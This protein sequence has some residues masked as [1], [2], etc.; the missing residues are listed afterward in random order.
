MAGYHV[1]KGRLFVF[2]FAYVDLRP[3]DV[4]FVIFSFADDFLRAGQVLLSNQHL[5]F[6]R[7]THAEIGRRGTRHR[8][9]NTRL[10]ERGND[11]A[12]FHLI[13]GG[14]GDHDVFRMFRM[15]GHRLTLWGKRTANFPSGDDLVALNYS[16]RE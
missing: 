1:E 13:L 5:N 7:Y 6:A 15:I 11:H 14:S 10:L 8:R 4:F 3:V 12:R 2:R 9:F 16:L